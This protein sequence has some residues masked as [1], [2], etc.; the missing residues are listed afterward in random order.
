M[1]GIDAVTGV[2]TK[3]L[4]IEA[5]GAEEVY[6]NK[7]GPDVEASLADALIIEGYGCVD[8]MFGPNIE[9]G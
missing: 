3:V 5:L 8:V 4:H 6:L 9:G 1:Q 7:L 2:V